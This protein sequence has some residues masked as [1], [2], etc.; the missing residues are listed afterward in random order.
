MRVV[1]RN[2]IKW[3]GIK[4]DCAL[5][6]LNPFM[7]E[8]GCQIGLSRNPLIFTT[9]YSN[10]PRIPPNGDH[11]SPHFNVKNRFGSRQ[12]SNDDYYK[13]FLFYF[14]INL[15]TGDRHDGL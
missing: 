5:V 7:F 11:I 8:H 15:T 12:K 3:E 2:E 10:Y 14:I 4:G 13:K 9:G 6:T 1:R